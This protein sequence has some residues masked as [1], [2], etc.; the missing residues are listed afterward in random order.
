ML[1]PYLQDNSF[2]THKIIQNTYES[3]QKKYSLSQF[4]I[5]SIL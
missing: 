5:G 2:S 3:N 1:I 4:A